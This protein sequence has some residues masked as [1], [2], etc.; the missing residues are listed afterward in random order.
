MPSIVLESDRTWCYAFSSASLELPRGQAPVPADRGG[1]YPTQLGRPRAT[2]QARTAV[3]AAQHMVSQAAVVFSLC[4]ALARSLGC[5][6]GGQPQ[7]GKIRQSG[8]HPAAM[9]GY[10]SPQSHSR[11]F[12]LA[13][14]PLFFLCSPPAHRPWPLLEHSW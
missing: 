12:A 3:I 6:V 5:S 4:A 9:G 13:E 10:G 14:M 7:A 8:R 2:A 1:C 11:T